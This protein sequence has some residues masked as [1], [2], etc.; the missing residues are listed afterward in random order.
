M[1][2]IGESVER[3][4]S[5][6]NETKEFQTVCAND[7]DKAAEVIAAGQQLIGSR[8]VYPWEIVQPKC[9]ELQRVCDIITERL[10]K[11]LD[12]LN[13]NRELME[14]VEKVKIKI[15]FQHSN[16]LINPFFVS[17]YYRL[18]NGVPMALNCLLHNVSRNVLHRMNWPNKVYKKFRH[19]LPLPPILSCLVPVNL[20]RFS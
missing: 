15:C 17:L 2:E 19:L 12:I 9:D 16:I 1:T 20:K 3:V 11:R 13:K 8:G 4:D 6:I 5:L 18:M 10:Q 7:I 14:R